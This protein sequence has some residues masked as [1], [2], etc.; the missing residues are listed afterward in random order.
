MKR[1]IVLM[2][3]CFA[4]TATF[5]QKKGKVDRSDSKE[6]EAIEY[7]VVRGIEIGGADMGSFSQEEMSDPRY[8]EKMSVMMFEEVQYRFTI[9]GDPRNLDDYV[10]EGIEGAQNP[11]EALNAAGSM[12]WELESSYAATRNGVTAHYY[13]L[14]KEK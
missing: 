10:G 9:L 14:A 7:L 5:A 2:V 6:S 11:M 8:Q 3:L 4:T 1:V 12:G 13:I